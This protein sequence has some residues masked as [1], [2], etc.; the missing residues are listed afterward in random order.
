M[1]KAII[2]KIIY[3]AAGL[4]ENMC[5]QIKVHERIQNAADVIHDEFQ[6][7]LFQ[8]EEADAERS[9]LRSWKRDLDAAKVD[10]SAGKSKKSFDLWDK[11]WKIKQ[12]NK[13]RSALM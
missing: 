2:R 4:E 13:R 3:E 6:E 12:Y 11:Y 9:W 8:Y 1:D 7:L 5:L 10:T